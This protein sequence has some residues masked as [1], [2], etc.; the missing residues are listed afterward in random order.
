MQHL[1]NRIDGGSYHTSVASDSKVEH[2]KVLALFGNE[3]P[4]G[5]C[6]HIKVNIQVNTK[7]GRIEPS[8]AEGKTPHLLQYIILSNKWGVFIS[9][10]L[11][12]F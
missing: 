7:F 2:N 10:S 11:E 5:G 1:Y 3:G 12:L 9:P 8:R 4:A 6:D